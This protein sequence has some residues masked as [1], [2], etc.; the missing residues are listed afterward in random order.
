MR[1]FRR[2]T[3]QSIDNFQTKIGAFKNS[4]WQYMTEA[5]S[6][7]ACPNGERP[8]TMRKQEF[9]IVSSDG[10]EVFESSEAPIQQ[11]TQYYD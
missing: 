5:C 11:K 9:V 4:L 2:K 6:G 7:R 3:T 1:S 8:S 10:R